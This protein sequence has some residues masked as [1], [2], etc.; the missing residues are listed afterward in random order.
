M[1]SESTPATVLIVDDTPLN[2]SILNAALMDY[3]TIKVATSGQQAIDICRSM[4]IDI[5][6]LDIMM[7]G[8]DGFETCR[9]LKGDPL[10]R[11]IPVIF[12]T[13][14]GATDDESMGFDCGAVDYITKP[15]R[16]A[17]VRAR[18]Q[19]HLALY[20]QSR[21]LER[22]VQERTAELNETR[23][24]VLRRLGS[25]GEY[26]DNDTGLHVVR[27]SSYSRIIAQ[28]LGLPENEAGLIY[29]AAALHDTG[30]IGIPDSIL[31]K[32]GKLDEEEWR[33]IRTHCEIGYKII[34]GTH[35]NILLKTAASIAL[36]HHEKWDGT[37]YPQNLKGNDIPF[38]GRIVAIAD[39]FD[40][41]TCVRPYK[42]AWS[43]NDAASE[44]VLCR[45]KNFD[46]L[47]VDA[48]LLKIP[49]LTA[50]LN[51]LVDKVSTN[52]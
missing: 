12:V 27:V 47:I 18:V 34:G 23:L 51:E 28:A 33:V 24:E 10:T 44:I 5:I 4:T 21:V 43:V 1:S 38:F 39:V 14:R 13:A 8:M 32:P 37:G 22:M 19:T 15:I 7:P 50:V 46:P 20:D 45:E 48:F 2:I 52:C 49:E 36:T 29:N 16:T 40:A 9:R 42:K 26:R 11:S 3:Y 30:K 41:L 25:A 17:I 31:L 35:N 6:L